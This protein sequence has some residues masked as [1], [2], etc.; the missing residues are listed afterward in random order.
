MTPRPKKHD[1][2]ADCIAAHR[3]RKADTHRRVELSL[4]IEAADKLKRIATN[5]ATTPSII[6]E[7]LISA[8]PET[9]A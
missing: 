4:P 5:E 3:Q 7:R 9:P 6:I 1:T 8:L 2:P